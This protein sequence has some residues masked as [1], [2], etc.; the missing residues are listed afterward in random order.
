M[1]ERGT[2]DPAELLPIVAREARV[3]HAAGGTDV[4]CAAVSVDGL[5]PLRAPAA[6]RLCRSRSFERGR[7]SYWELDHEGGI[8]H[9]DVVDDPEGR[10]PYGFP[11]KSAL[12]GDG[13]DTPA[14]VVAAYLAAKRLRKGDSSGEAWERIRALAAVDL[15]A[16]E[17]GLA[18]MLGAKAAATL[19]SEALAGTPS[20]ATRAAARRAQR[21]RRRTVDS[22]SEALEHGADR[23]RGVLRPPGLR[24]L[25]VGP[26][27]TGKSTLAA[28]LPGATGAL[29][30]DAARFHWRPGLL[31]SLGPSLGQSAVDPA[32]PFGRRP[33]SRPV[34]LGL[35][36]Y[37]WVDF[38]LG[39]LARQRP[40]LA[41]TGLI[42]V[43]RGW[44]DLE[45]DLPR[46][47]LAVPRSLVRLLGRFVPA[48]DLVLVLETQPDVAAARKPEL[49]PDE[50]A[51]QSA[52][53]R[54]AAARGNHAVIDTTD[55]PA[56]DVA[57]AARDAIV[58]A[59]EHRAVSRLGH[60]WAV[61]PGSG[62]RKVWVPRGPRAAA[63]AGALV[64][65]PATRRARLG[66]RAFEA[67]A[68]LGLLRLAPRAAPPRE[69]RELVAEHVPRGATYA[70]ASSPWANRYV[71]LL[72]DAGGT[73]LS[74][75]KLGL[76]EAASIA[77]A[78]E[79]DSIRSA[80]S[81][82]A[83]SVRAPHI[84]DEGEGALVLE[85]VR[86]RPP[87]DSAALPPEVATALGRLYRDAGGLVHGDVAPWNLLATDEG[88]VLVDWEDSTAQGRPYEDVFHFHVQAHVFLGRPTLSEI[89]AVRGIGPVASSLALYAEAAELPAATTDDLVRYLERTGRHIERFLAT[90]G[91]TAAAPGAR[92]EAEARRA[93]VAAVQ[94]SV[95]ADRA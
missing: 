9:L 66:W 10:G 62:S 93:L 69:F 17:D 72:L 46:Y 29:F 57:A 88:W 45:I 94:A 43:E 70:V 95:A 41:R 6:W 49:P 12:Q 92:R 51:R 35:L 7:G 73:P 76:D 58:G 16:F 74:L 59:L 18:R 21:Q 13:P 85:A 40:R 32:T 82:L 86:W 5:W 38:T 91:A 3:L 68:R 56:D 37:Y 78:R 31:P 42:V 20:P 19:A 90:A 27:G 63:A 77:L 11:T 15:T 89:V 67:A 14:G 53:W 84:L 50:H 24:V 2:P 48:A 65:M 55:L 47:R 44:P 25:I 87:R 80:T 23:I 30:R 33:H 83:G 52:A 61:A 8:V 1:A 54:S 36:V 71:A 64:Y 39:S 26:D 81:V 60:G 28:K 79:A 22:L 34:S 75:V 4:D